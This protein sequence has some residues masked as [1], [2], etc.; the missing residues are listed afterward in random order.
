MATKRTKKQE[1]IYTLVFMIITTVICVT[2]VSTVYQFTKPKIKRNKQL[3]EMTAVL[4]ALDVIDTSKASPD[5][6]A[7]QFDAEKG[8]EVQRWNLKTVEPFVVED[9]VKGI[10]GDDKGDLVYYVKGKGFA[11]KQIGTGL[12]GKMFAIVGVD[13]SL[14][15]LTGVCFT[16]QNETPGLGARISEDW[17]T[18]Q[19]VG[20]TGPLKM[21]KAEP[22]DKVEGLNKN[23]NEFDAVSGATITSTGVRNMLNA[24]FEQ[25]IKGLQ[26]LKNKLVGAALKD[27][28]SDELEEVT[29]GTE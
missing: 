21:I 18:L 11:F 25:K 9:K 15:R 3:V 28:L 20:K 8:G 5:E 10:E 24:A 1:A 6:I 14:T 26:A 29:G 17:F 13:E 12:W 19:L 7:D 16:S 2:G 23:S 22:K 27:A 4:K